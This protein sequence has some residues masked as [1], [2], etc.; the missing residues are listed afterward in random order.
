VR[1]HDDVP[2]NIHPSNLITG[3]LVDNRQDAVDRDRQARGESQG[4]AKL[5]EDEVMQIRMLYAQGR[6]QV[7]LA[8]QFHVGTTTISNITL[9]RTWRHVPKDEGN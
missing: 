5:T 9:G 1:H 2:L 7:Q 3:T 6:S 8:E 4:L